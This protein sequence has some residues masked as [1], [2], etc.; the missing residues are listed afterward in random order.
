MN[1][2]RRL[3]VLQKP[4]RADEIRASPQ[5]QSNIAGGRGAQYN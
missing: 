1:P 3:P 4:L 5:Q 2:Y